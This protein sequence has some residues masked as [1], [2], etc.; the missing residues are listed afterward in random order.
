MPTLSQFA[1]GLIQALA[2]LLLAPLASGFSRMIRATLHSRTGPGLLQNYRDI[3]KLLKRQDVSPEGAGLVFRAMPF[4]MLATLLLVAMTLPLLTHDAPVGAAGDLIAVIYLLA[5]V[6]FFFAL[7]GIDSGNTFA[8]I[9]ASR[10]LTMAVLIE[11]VIFLSLLVAG[12]LA[13]STSL[14]AI[15]AAFGTGSIGAIAAGVT[16]TIAFA[17]AMFVEMGKL[18]YDMAEAEQELQEGPLTEY[19]GPGLALLKLAI[20]LKQVVM[21]AML[22]G[23]FVPFGAATTMAVPALVGAALAVL[24]KLAVVFLVIGLIENSVAR[25]RFMLASRATWAGFGIASLA[26]AFYLAGL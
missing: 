7:S 19:S 8:G 17:F 25:S 4:V 26:F 14:G 13:G 10:E 6:R 20:S 16:A 15:S 3:L 2:L 11:P 18:P 21:A 12:L 24:L 9:G 5:L 23:V 1:L 22:I